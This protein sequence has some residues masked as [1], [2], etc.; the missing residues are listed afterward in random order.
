MNDSRKC[1]AQVVQR[2]RKQT[3]FANLPEVIGDYRRSGQNITDHK[4]PLLG[5]EGAKITAATLK[6]IFNLEVTPEEF[7]A[8]KYLTWSHD[9]YMHHTSDRS[10][11]KQNLAALKGLFLRV[12]EANAGIKFLKDR[13]LLKSMQILWEWAAFNRSRSDYNRPGGETRYPVHSITSLFDPNRRP[14]FAERWEHFCQANPGTRA[15]VAGLLKKGGRLAKKVRTAIFGQTVEQWTWD[16]FLRTNKAVER[17]TWDRFL[18]TSKKMDRMYARFDSKL[19]ELEKQAAA[20]NAFLAELNFERHKRP[21][22]PGEKIK[23]GFF[24]QVPSFW[25]S[26]EALYKALCNDDRFETV[27]IYCDEDLDPSIKTEGVAAF[28]ESRN[29]PA[30]SYKD[31]DLN[32]AKLNCMVLQ[33]IWDENRPPQYSLSILKSMGIRLIFT[34]YGVEFPDTKMAREDHYERPHYLY[35]WRIYTFSPKM[36]PYYNTYCRNSRAVR[37]L[38]APRFDSIFHKEE[39]GLAEALQEKKGGRPFF[40]WKAHFPKTMYENGRNVLVTPDLMEYLQFVS[41]IKSRPE[42]FFVFMPHPRFVEF[43]SNGRLAG[44]ARSLLETL[45]NVPNVYVDQADD[46]RPTLVHA[47]Y[48][49]VDRSAV[50]VEAGAFGAPVLFMRNA[51]CEEPLT[52]AV[53]PLMESYYQGGTCDDMIEFVEMCL[54]GEDDK[55]EERLAAWRECM[56]LFDGRASERIKDDI[57]ASVMRDE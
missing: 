46:Y 19:W 41:F 18:R 5:E 32:G 33:T 38:G 8:L 44:Q 34:S 22:T 10:E 17:W 36:L 42:L 21:Y 40:L 56:P 6:R 3:E 49:I 45:K 15:R 50:M 31:F 43:N 39:Y 2:P 25:A 4:R 55:K 48:I 35:F 11:I 27:V 14:T 28:L 13:A 57:A 9:R 26:L 52:D 54:R 53:K 20:N 24:F 16:R 47:D 7:E 23:I 37:A 12:W 1:V 51:S 29:M 30:I